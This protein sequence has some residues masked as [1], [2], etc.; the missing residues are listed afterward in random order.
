LAFL[1]KEG[2]G[3]SLDL[4]LSGWLERNNRKRNALISQG[5]WDDSGW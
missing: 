1:Q 5:V 4:S 3:R 2:F